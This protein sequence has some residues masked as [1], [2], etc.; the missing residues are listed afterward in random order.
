MTGRFLCWVACAG[1]CLGTLCWAIPAV[2]FGDIVGILV[3]I[4][5]AAMAVGYGALALRKADERD[6]T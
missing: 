5:N 4:A 2:V 1:W 6:R 3:A